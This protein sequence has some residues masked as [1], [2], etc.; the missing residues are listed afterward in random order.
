MLIRA[1]WLAI[2]AFGVALGQLL[3][4]S[5]S[6]EVFVLFWALF[7]LALVLTIA[8]SH[9][10]DARHRLGRRLEHALRRRMGQPR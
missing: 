9:G 8:P 7:W 1:L 2:I 10:A 6:T 3:K 4:L 5:T